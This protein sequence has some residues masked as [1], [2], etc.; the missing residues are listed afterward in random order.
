MEFKGL[1]GLC[2]Y[3]KQVIHMEENT[4]L[5]LED[6]CAV[7][8]QTAGSGK[9]CAEGQGKKS[10]PQQYSSGSCL[11]LEFPPWLTDHYKDQIEVNQ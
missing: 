11:H 6:K 10:R 4:E 7:A 3:T 2:G 8:M 1:F 5:L 9:V